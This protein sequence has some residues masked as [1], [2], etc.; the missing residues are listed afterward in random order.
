MYELI[1]LSREPNIKGPLS[2]IFHCIFTCMFMRQV[3]KTLYQVSEIFPKV[4]QSAWNDFVAAVNFLQE[5]SDID[6]KG[7]HC[8]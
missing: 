3:D 7:P 6:L 1:T 8:V 5:V 2:A 4:L